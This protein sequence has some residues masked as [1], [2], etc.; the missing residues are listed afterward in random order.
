MYL[1]Q[2]QAIT[3]DGARIVV[4]GGPAMHHGGTVK[5]DFKPGREDI[6]L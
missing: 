6:L 5:M 4:I 1:L 3:H 2:D